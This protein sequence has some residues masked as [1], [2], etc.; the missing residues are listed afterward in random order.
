MCTTIYCNSDFT[1]HKSKKPRTQ[2]FDSSANEI[3]CN[4]IDLKRCIGLA[5]EFMAIALIQKPK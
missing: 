1:I 2:G 3:M 5:S 4:W